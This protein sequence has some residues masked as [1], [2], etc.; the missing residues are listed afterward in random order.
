M[1][2]RALLA[3]IAAGTT[4]CLAPA[5]DDRRTTAGGTEDPAGTGTSSL[6][7]GETTERPTDYPELGAPAADAG[8]PPFD[9]TVA[10]VVWWGEAEPT[11]PVR[12]VADPRSGSLPAAKFRFSLVNDSDRRF[13]YN[14]YDWGL[15]KR[16]DGSW[17]YV[18]PRIVPQPLSYLAPG[19]TKTWTLAVGDGE[20]SSTDID[21]LGDA[22]TTDRLGGGTYA[23]ET[24]GW[25]EDQH[26]TESTALAVRFAL[27]GDAVTPT[28]DD[29]VTERTRNGST[30]TIRTDVSSTERTRP[31]VLVVERVDGPTAE[32]RIA[33]QVVRDPL[34]R[35]TLPAFETG[36]D[37]VRLVEPNGA[38]PPFGVSDPRTFRYAGESYRVTAREAEQGTETATA[39]ESETA[40]G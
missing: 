6:A 2:R 31:C 30:V 32:R 13:G 26:Y 40:G 24:D 3:S 37:R 18:A 19:E 25:F 38:V 7:P 23:F 39:T 4:G 34:L 20:A 29:S 16:V 14:P 15:W 35:K 1:F 33:E 27:S 36:V 8:G 21:T 10:R 22:I 12:L 9:D 17:F 11:D 28:L 5:S